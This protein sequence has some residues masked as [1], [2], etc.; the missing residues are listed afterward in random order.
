V[1][2]KS[3]Q[4]GI[5][6][7][8]TEGVR[9]R[10]DS[11]ERKDVGA[12]EVGV[13]VDAVAA[14]IV[15]V[16]EADVEGIEIWGR[17][18]VRDIGDIAGVADNGI[19]VAGADANIDSVEILREDGVRGVGDNIVGVSI[20]VVSGRVD[21]KD[22]IVVLIVGGRGVVVVDVVEVEVEVRRRAGGVSGEWMKV[23]GI[24]CVDGNEVRMTGERGTGGDDNANGIIA[25]TAVV[26]IISTMVAAAAAGTVTVITC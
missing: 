15:V 14:V 6:V 7:G 4:D 10:N 21:F 16:A 2:T 3:R 22:V 12:D 20:I 11:G 18:R 19:A 17:A 24:R 9:K 1:S 26:Y 8:A 13:I 5:I 23:T 25:I